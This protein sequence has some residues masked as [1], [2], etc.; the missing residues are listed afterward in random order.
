MTEMLDIVVAKLAALS[1]QE[2]DRI[3][4][5]L[6][7]ELP[8]EALWERQFSES[9]EALAKLAAETRAERATGSTTELDPTKL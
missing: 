7:Q 6:L 5:W 4:Q 3:A 2:Q 1:P 9:Q 8:D